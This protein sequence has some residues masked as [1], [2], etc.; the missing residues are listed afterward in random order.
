[1][2]LKV[3]EHDLANCEICQ[4]KKSEKLPVPRDSGTRASEVLETVHTD[5]LGP[6][7]PE[8]VD[9]HRYAIGFVDSF[10]RYQ[11][12]YFL[13]TRDEAFEKVEQFFADIGQPGTLFCDGAGEYVSNDIKQLC[14][15]K[16][17]RLEFS[18][19]YTPQENGKVERNWWTITPMA[20][21]LLEQSGLEKEYW[22]YALNMASENKNFCFHSG[23]QKTPF[24]AMYKKKPNLESLQVFGCSAFVHVEKIFRGKIDRTSQK[25]IFLGSSDNSKTY[26]VGIQNDK[27]V[28]KVGKSRN[29]TFNENETFIE[30]KEKKEEI[31]NKH[32]S[33]GDRG[34]NPVAF[35]GEI[36]YNELLPKS[37]DEAIRDKNWY[38][39]MKLEN[40]SLVEN[41]VWELVENKGNKPIGNRWHFALKF[42][43]S[44][45]I[46]RY[47]S[48]F[49]AKG[50]SQ[51]PGRDYNETYSPKTP[52]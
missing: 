14:R 1:M 11:K 10:S 45:E 37:I 31:V 52:S 29:V 23:I 36:V 18:A 51:V 26:L 9:G 3:N 16:G 13:R 41:K 7:Q 8:A 39:A 34:I 20:R 21:C 17:V 50:F 24:E 25:G 2:G 27:G 35:L 32:H 46:T 49:V 48:R 47:K 19:P 40:N 15:R 22:P 43:P 6:I 28:F 5:I 33:D 44:G 12:L 4:L 30:V 38:E 42:G